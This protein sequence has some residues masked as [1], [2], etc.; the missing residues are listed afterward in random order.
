MNGLGIGSGHDDGGCARV[1]D[2]RCGANGDGLATHI[3]SRKADFPVPAATIIRDAIRKIQLKANLAPPWISNCRN[4][5]Q[6]YSEGFPCM[7]SR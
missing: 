7:L 2:G 6:L 3:H 4:L 5:P 1:D